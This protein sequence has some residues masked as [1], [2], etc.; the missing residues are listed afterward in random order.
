MHLLNLLGTD[1][2]LLP[3]KAVYIPGLKILLVAD[4]HLGKSETFQHRG[5]PIPHQVNLATLRRLQTLSDQLKP[6]Q[7]VIL[8][9]LFHS[10]SALVEEVLNA[11]E[12]F[13][14]TLNLDVTLIVGNH[15]RP[16]RA[17]LTEKEIVNCHEVVQVENLIFSHEFYPQPGCINF[18][19]HIHPCVK[20]QTKLDRLRLPC[21]YLDQSQTVLIL[22]SFGEFTGS[23]EMPLGQGKAAY[24]IAENTVIPL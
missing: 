21:F 3:E 4:V 9:D 1:L 17:A 22:P 2:W 23:H 7:L 12:S 5:V 14:A 24:V 13:L 6:Q 11:W 10:R 20:I 16:L 19:G 18:C 8:G 15:D